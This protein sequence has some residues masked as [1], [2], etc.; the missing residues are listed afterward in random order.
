M[1]LN[2]NIIRVSALA[3]W[4]LHVGNSKISANVHLSAGPL[5]IFRILM[6]LGAVSFT[7]PKPQPSTQ[8]RFPLHP[9]QSEIASGWGKEVARSNLKGQ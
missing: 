2:A 9:A 1:C 3:A 7:L 4:D 8:A 5:L 6:I